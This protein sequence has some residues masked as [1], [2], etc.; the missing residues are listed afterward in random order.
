MKSARIPELKLLT[1][2]QLR[3]LPFPQASRTIA[4]ALVL[5]AISGAFLGFAIWS[6]APSIIAGGLHGALQ[7]R[8]TVT[9]HNLAKP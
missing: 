9:H 8:I 1:T 3:C 5:A 6:A 4:H 2:P 7:C